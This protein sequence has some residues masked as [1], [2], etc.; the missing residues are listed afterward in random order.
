MTF[1]EADDTAVGADGSC[2][3]ML[4][5]CELC[6][7]VAL[8]GQVAEVEVL[9]RQSVVV[10]VEEELSAQEVVAGPWAQ[11]TVVEVVSLPWLKP[12]FAWPRW[13]LAH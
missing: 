3:G 10:Q 6:A 9:V 7:A 2:L 11:E 12:P 5:R 8:A 1:A 4:G 13:P